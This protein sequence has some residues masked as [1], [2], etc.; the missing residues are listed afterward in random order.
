MN[1]LNR[2]LRSQSGASILLALLF[3]LTCMMV[4]ASI[5]M[6]AV[7]NAGKI[8]SNYDEQQRYLALSSALRL[9]A[10]EIEEATYRG[11]YTVQRWEVPV[12]D[13]DGKPTEEVTK[14]YRVKQAE[15]DFTCGEL[16]NR[17]NFRSELDG[18]FGREFTGTGYRPLDDTTLPPRSE[19]LIVEVNDGAEAKLPFTVVVSVELRQDL[20]VHLK[21]TLATN[22]T[23][24]GDG[25]PVF[26]GK[27][28]T[29]EAELAPSGYPTLK[30]F[31]PGSDEFPAGSTLPGGAVELSSTPRVTPAEPDIK[32]WELQWISKGVAEG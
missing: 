27:V 22:L 12:L 9:V 16:K 25:T 28:Y 31:T 10:G 18:V 17:L 20:R 3:L 32:N 5:L 15:G 24:E 1:K 2:K 19:T 29:M 13:D 30:D 21:A 14:Y 11:D 23:Y 7:S 26:G 6:A 4:A 8:R